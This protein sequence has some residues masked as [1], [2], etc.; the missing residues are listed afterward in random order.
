MI[1]IL[2]LCANSISYFPK[3]VKE[4]DLLYLMISILSLVLLGARI[5]Y[6]T[7]LE[8]IKKNEGMK[9]QNSSLI[10]YLIL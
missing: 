4:L 2:I 1:I 10:T 3:E 8:L 6:Q 5:C 9:S 7:C